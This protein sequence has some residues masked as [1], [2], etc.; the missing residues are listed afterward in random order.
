[1][2][3]RNGF[4]SNS[5]SSSFIITNKSHPGIQVLINHRDVT[6]DLE[7]GTVEDDDDNAVWNALYGYEYEWDEF[8]EQIAFSG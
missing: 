5:S 7:N 8:L 2:K 3:V 1:M 6:V 4:V